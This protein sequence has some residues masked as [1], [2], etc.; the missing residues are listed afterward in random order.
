[1]R[2]GTVTV[3][4]GGG[5]CEVTTYRVEGAYTDHRR[6]DGVRFT[7]SLEADLARR[8]F[9][10]NAMAMDAAGRVTDPFGGREDL[11]GGL[12][13]ASASRSGAFARTRCGCCAP[14]A[15][16]PSWALR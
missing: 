9:T 13:A 11:A 3:L 10:I 12:S 4:Y 7:A 14:C 1:M 8:D 6:P 16:P 15:S 2:H 5:H